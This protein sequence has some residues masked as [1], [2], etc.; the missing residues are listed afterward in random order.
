MPLQEWEIW[1]QREDLMDRSHHREKVV[2]ASQ[3]DRPQEKPPLLTPRSW[4]SSFQGCEKINF[5]CWPSQCVVLCFSPSKLTQ[6]FSIS[7][8][9]PAEGPSGFL[10]NTSLLT[11]REKHHTDW[12]I[13]IESDFEIYSKVPI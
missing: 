4:T 6:R 10:V 11:C 8:C 3:G 1:T 12:V 9:G 5:S 7:P 2:C 13:W